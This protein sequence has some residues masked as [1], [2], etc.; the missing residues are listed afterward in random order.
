MDAGVASI[1]VAVV[2]AGGALGTKV[3]SDLAA[4]RRQVT[5]SNGVPTAEI[6]EAV[7]A[8]VSAL[9]SDLGSVKDDVQ[10][11]VTVQHGRGPTQD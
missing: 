2:T 10:Y 9:R 7:K 3:V 8:E 11:H 4:I 1:V 5:P 6:I